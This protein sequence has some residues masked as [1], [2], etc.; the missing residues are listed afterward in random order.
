MMKGN[1]EW[2]ECPRWHK[3]SAAILV[4]G[5]I[6]KILSAIYLQLADTGL[7]VFLFKPVVLLVIGIYEFLLA[8]MLLRARVFPVAK[9][10]L[11]FWTGTAFLATHVFL[12]F[13][14]IGG[15]PCLG[16]FAK[17]GGVFSGVLN[18]VVVCSAFYIFG[19]SFYYF[20]KELRV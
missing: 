5:G 12:Y 8:A 18:A 6:A 11:A 15:C 10:M 1:E 14:K 17:T 7:N 16:I 19:G 13:L 2:A 9:L 20:R 4:I 3:V